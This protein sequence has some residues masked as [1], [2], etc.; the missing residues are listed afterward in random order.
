MGEESYWG[1]LIMG[2]RHM[3]T[4]EIAC[5]MCMYHGMISM[6]NVKSM[7]FHEVYVDPSNLLLYFSSWT[8]HI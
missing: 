1:G 5:K 6:L 2:I 3:Y 7:H 4:K 8:E